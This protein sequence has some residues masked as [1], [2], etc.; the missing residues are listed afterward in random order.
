MGNLR[1]SDRVAWG[2]PG[3]S[4]PEQTVVRPGAVNGRGREC[5]GGEG[6]DRG[7]RVGPPADGGDRCH[8]GT[9]GPA[10]R[11]GQDAEEP[12]LP[13]M[14]PAA[15]HGTLRTREACARVIV[16]I[17]TRLYSSP[18]CARG[19]RARK[20][21]RRWMIHALSMSSSRV[22]R[23]LL[24]LQPSRLLQQSGSVCANPLSMCGACGNRQVTGA[25]R[26]NRPALSGSEDRR[27]GNS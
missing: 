27:K 2:N 26:K 8:V 11:C 16:G 24:W 12:Y 9:W 25:T 14:G 7:R 3:P 18:G 10:T 19:C 23:H 4:A 5:R 13:R 6:G 20:K 17:A 22:S 1:P 15:W 21:N